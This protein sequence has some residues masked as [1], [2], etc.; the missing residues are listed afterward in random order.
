MN[1]DSILMGFLD[2]FDDFVLAIMGEC[3][4]LKENVLG[5][6]FGKL[7]KIDFLHA[8]LVNPIS[9]SLAQGGLYGYFKCS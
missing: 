7:F 6:L 1:L 2:P 9:V 5:S 8:P 3:S 4:M